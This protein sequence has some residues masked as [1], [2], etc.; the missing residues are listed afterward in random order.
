MCLITT[1][2]SCFDVV[3]RLGKTGYGPG[4]VSKKGYGAGVGSS[5]AVRLCLIS[6]TKFDG[7]SN[8]GRLTLSLVAAIAAGVVVV[9]NLRSTRLTF[10][11]NYS[12]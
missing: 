7:I 1:L 8:L 12:G 9:S 11:L 2:D 6:Y 3:V 10:V 4:K 5:D